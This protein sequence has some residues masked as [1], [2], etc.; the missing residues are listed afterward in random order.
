MRSDEERS[1]ELRTL[2]LVAN[3]PHPV[4]HF[5]D[6]LR[7]S[8]P[9]TSTGKR[10][11]TSGFL[12]RSILS[13]THTRESGLSAGPGK[14]GGLIYT[15]STCTGFGRTRRW[16][17]GGVRG[18]RI[19]CAAGFSREYIYVLLYLCVCSFLNLDMIF[20]WVV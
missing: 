10:G 14:G 12:K 19:L 1:D 6:S 18:L 15:A 11:A 4:R 2:A 5:C 9:Y 16:G 3:V 8:Q 17:G 7:S 20:T 13:L